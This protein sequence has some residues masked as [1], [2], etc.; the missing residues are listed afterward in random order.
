MAPSLS[1]EAHA[2]QPM[3]SLIILAIVMSLLVIS[4]LIL[5]L[6]F[7]RNIQLRASRVQVA[8]DRIDTPG[9]PITIASATDGAF[10][11]RETAR[12]PDVTL[13]INNIHSSDEPHV[14]SKS[15][16]T[17]DNNTIVS[18]VRAHPVDTSDLVPI[19]Q[20][21]IKLDS[22]LFLNTPRSSSSQS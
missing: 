11:L 4:A 20:A 6:V 17:F 9:A 15:D 5:A 12:W 18:P 3:H 7:Y 19:S 21:T 13:S 10:A 22:G 2:A 1:I 16:P 14:V 8:G